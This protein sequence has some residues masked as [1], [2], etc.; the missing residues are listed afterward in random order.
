MGLTIAEDKAA[1]T[2]FDKEMK[3]S[4]GGELNSNTAGSTNSANVSR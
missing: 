3:F 1:Q 4:G 2:S